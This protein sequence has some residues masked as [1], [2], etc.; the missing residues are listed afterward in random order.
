MVP[1]D[2][3][4]I[5]LGISETARPISKYRLLA[6]DD[7]EDNREV[8]SAAAERQ[9]IYLRT[10]QAGE[11]EV[12]VAQLLNEVSQARVCLL[13]GKSKSRYDTQLRS[14]LEPAPEQDPLAFAAE[15]LASISSRPATRSRSQRGK[16]FWQRPWAIPAAA[17]G[18]V[19]LLL[20]MW[21]F[22]GDESKPAEKQQG[23]ATAKVERKPNLP[24]KKPER[25]R[26]AAAEKSAIEKA[27]T[28]TVVTLKG[29]SRSVRSVAFSP[30]GKQIVSGGGD[31]RVKLWDI[32]TEQVIHTF[33]GHSDNV[34]S[35][36]FSP[37]GK[38][39]VSGSKDRLLKVWNTENGEEI[40]SLKGHSDTVRSVAFS[41]D[42]KRIVSG[43]YDKTMRVWDVETGQQVRTL[44]NLA[45][46]NSVAFS[47]DGK[48][49]VSGSYD[50]TVKVWDA[51]TGR[52]ILTF[53]GHSRPVHS[54]AFSPDEKAI[55]SG[56][57]DR[58]IK[59]FDA[60]TGAQTV[61]ITEHTTWVSSVAF[62]PDSKQ[63]VS[64]DYDNAL[65][66]WD[67]QTGQE[68]VTLKG[69]EYGINSV[70]FSPDGTRIV[71]GGQDGTIKIW[72]LGAVENTS[73]P[74]TKSLLTNQEVK[75]FFTTGNGK[76]HHC[77]LASPV[78]EEISISALGV[79]RI[80]FVEIDREKKE[81]LL[82]GATGPEFPHFQSGNSAE[83]IGHGVFVASDFTGA[84]QRVLLDGSEK[85]ISATLQYCMA[86]DPRTSSL[87]AGHHHGLARVGIV[88][89][90]A[91][92]VGYD[93]P[94]Y[95]FDLEID[96][97]RDLM[98]VTENQRYNGIVR[99]NCNGENQKLIYASKK[100][101]QLFLAVDQQREIL[102]FSV[103]SMNVIMQTNY[104][105]A[106]VKPLVYTE[107]PTDLE[108]DAINKVL[109]WINSK[110][111]YQYSIV[112]KTAQQ[113]IDL[114]DYVEKH[115]SSKPPVSVG[116][117]EVFSSK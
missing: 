114:T 58:Q 68:M 38:W 85:G 22:G 34:N 108:Y 117:L 72:D 90:E 69:H 81:L 109:Y 4:H 99:S 71:S 7:F 78:P 87:Y 88:N 15:E 44:G 64:A 73:S 75:F 101:Q 5:W 55:V 103:P 20:L 98:F 42:G 45:G 56:G 62:S 50:H 49:I 77:S 60:V 59:M 61:S 53:S 17:G 105:G 47:P 11:H 113:V 86:F 16:P 23:P 35:V 28:E 91:V 111:I 67:A 79:K 52:E 115:G 110:G 21:L 97:N 76:V 107:N 63:I 39:I 48:R 3:Y 104:E 8:I 29:H 43:S 65:R 1:F 100:Y 94:L 13:D 51:E 70:A 33:K 6:I 14:Q 10:L 31:N 106:N 40:T 54:A 32:K 24:N 18:V 82:W 93:Y 92:N 112:G 57:E 66:V 30:D 9:T 46:V 27:A 84:N 80:N 95:F 37:D 36:A 74:T 2:P 25:A 12:L 83:Q 89:S 116:S 41:P 19:V 26:L 96:P 102:Y